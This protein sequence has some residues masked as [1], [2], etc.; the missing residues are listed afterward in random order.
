MQ[1]PGNCFYQ[2]FY[3]L[4]IFLCQNGAHADNRLPFLQ[5][6]DCGY[7]HFP[8]PASVL[9]DLPEFFIGQDIRHMDIGKTVFQ[10]LT[11]KLCNT[12]AI[13]THD[14]CCHGI[15]IQLLPGCQKIGGYI[16]NLVVID[17]KPEVF[18]KQDAE[19][20]GSAEHTGIFILNLTKQRVPDCHPYLHPA[21]HIGQMVFEAFVQMP[22][23][24]YTDSKNAVNH[25][26]ELVDKA[27]EPGGF[28][29]TVPYIVH[30]GISEYAGEDD[31]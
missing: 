21:D 10:F 26:Q 31:I 18:F 29:D 16:C 30:A 11:D 3:G 6:A 5:R 20:P 8:A 24:G 28:K 23:L 13:V 12:D 19:G 14:T 15:V 4:F 27:C 22:I 7:Y 17:H 1:F 9:A 2:L 25:F